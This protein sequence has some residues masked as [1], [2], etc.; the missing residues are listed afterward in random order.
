MRPDPRVRRPEIS[1][2]P[3]LRL[4]GPLAGGARNAIWRAEGPDRRS[5]VIKST[6]HSEAALRWL[7]P[8]HDAARHAGIVVPALCENSNGLLAPMGWTCEPVIEG[9]LASAADLTMLAPRLTAFH[10]LA[11]KLPPRP[12]LEGYCTNPVRP[13][14]LPSGLA[15]RIDAALAPMATAATGTI[16]AD[17][18]PGNVILTEAGPAL[19]DWDEAR[20]DWLFLD[21]ITTR[22]AS[23]PE[24]RAALACEILNC[25][26]PEPERARSLAARLDPIFPN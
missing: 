22:Q 21:Q 12:G 19:I 9:P 8:V 7:L 26:N 1:A 23:P 20:H 17:I 15:G 24:A 25:W 5:W 11:A 10:Q 14:D 18:N 13:A 4:I 3:D 6:S 16:H 2:W